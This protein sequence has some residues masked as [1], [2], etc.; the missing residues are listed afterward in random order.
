MDKLGREG[1]SESREREEK[2]KETNS[3][4]AQSHVKADLGNLPQ[5]VNT[6]KYKHVIREMWLNK[7]LNRRNNIVRT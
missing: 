5:D 4:L 6:Y 2:R 7:R 3:V 1:E